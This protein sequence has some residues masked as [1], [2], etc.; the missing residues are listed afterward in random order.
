MSDAP[1]DPRSITSLD[2]LLNDLKV[3]MIVRTPGDFNAFSFEE[4]YRQTGGFPVLSLSFRAAHGG[5]RKDPK[6]VARALPSFFANL[7][8][9]DK[10]REAM[11]RHHSGSV[12]AGNDF[13]LLAA[14]GSDLPGAVRIVPSEGSVVCKEGLTPPRPK[15][16]F[17]LA[18]VQMK[19]SVIKNTGKGG[20]LTIPLG[21]EQGSYIAKFPSTSFPSVSENEFANLALAEAIGMDVP[22]RELVEQSQFEGI[23]EEFET[24]SDGKVLLVKRFD[25]VAGGERIHIEDFAQVFGVYPSRK[26]EGASYHDIAVAIGVAVSSAAALE[27][28]RRLALAVLTGNG[29]MHLKNWSLIYHGKGNKPALAPVYDVLSTVPYIPSDAMAL[30]LAGERPFK[31]MNAQRWKVFA[32]R[33]RL[34]EA[35]VLKAVTETVERVNQSWW[36]LPERAVLPERVLERID[37]HIKLMSPILGTC[38]N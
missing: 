18:G 27:F 19:L 38:A 26:Y 8:P 32:H 35:A 28:V 17:S 36:S 9:E 2:V 4:S 37:A 7:L 24:L 14:L 30:S 34:P 15:A 10:L 22:E 5:L 20:G 23:P 1:L 3:G 11:E 13:D 12:R 21:D 16:R 6:P 33:A 29:D 25:R 31:A